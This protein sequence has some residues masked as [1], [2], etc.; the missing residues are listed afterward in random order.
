MRRQANGAFVPP[1]RVTTSVNDD[2]FRP[3]ASRAPGGGVLVTYHRFS[4]SSDGD[5]LLHRIR[6][7]G[8]NEALNI[9][10]GRGS[11]SQL[12]GSRV[13]VA[14][15]GFAYLVFQ[16]T[17]PDSDPTNSEFYAAQVDLGN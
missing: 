15:D 11:V 12:F 2:E 8:S 13:V 17:V 7:D 16:E 10:E 1:V 3:T 14:G 9:T 5:V 4:G 6:N